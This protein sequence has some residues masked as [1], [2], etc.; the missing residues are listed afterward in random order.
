MIGAQVHIGFRT[1]GGRGEYEVVGS[2]TGLN[3]LDLEGWTFSMRWPDGQVRDTGLWVDPAASGKARL[4][5]MFTPPIQI[6]RI[7]APMLLLPDPARTYRTTPTTEPIIRVKQYSITEI[8]FGV[9]SEFSEAPGLVTFDPSFV[10]VANQGYRDQ[11]GVTARWGRIAA[12]Y[13][14]TARLPLAV[15]PLVQSHQEYLASGEVVTTRLATIVASVSRELTQ[16]P[17][18]YY[19]EGTDPLLGLER[20]LG[21]GPLRGPT[22]PPPDEL[23]EDAP[24]VSARS[25]HEYRLAKIRGASGRNFSRQVRATYGDRCA[26]CGAKFGG[27][28]G[29]RSGID[30]AHILAWSR[31]DLDV[32]QNG[33]ALCKLHHWAFDAGI[34]MPRKEGDDYYIRFTSL[35]DLV[36]PIS[37]TRL[38]ADGERIPDEWLP[39]DPK[40]RPST[41]YLE[42]LYADLGVTFKDDV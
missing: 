7:V 6:G 24:E 30:A 29:I 39:G 8:G 18:A 33:I 27:I 10:T 5:S 28:D 12:V 17:N 26:F 40:L 9:G 2:H 16:C 13:A 19:T 21:L 14:Q 4:R 3:P 11:I 34:L 20:V 41:S 25:A 32:V 42:R 15:Q 23:G 22:L 38:G 35:A 36:D 1:S 31:H 37:M